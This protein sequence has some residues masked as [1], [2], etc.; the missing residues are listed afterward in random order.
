[1]DKYNE[2]SISAKTVK[3]LDK[4]Q[5]LLTTKNTKVHHEGYQV[6]FYSCLISDKTIFIVDK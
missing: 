5:K 6:E 4:K 3:T 2:F 1:M